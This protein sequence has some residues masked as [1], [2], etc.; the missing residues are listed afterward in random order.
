M[1]KTRLSSK[2]QVVLP[3]SVHDTR[4][5]GPGMEFAVEEVSGGVLLRLLRPFKS[6]TVDE[7]YGCLR[8][9]GW[10]KTLGQMK[11]AIA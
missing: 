11:R 10:A 7:V 2:G 8:F 6:A 4:S 5:W 3:K 9:S 1:K